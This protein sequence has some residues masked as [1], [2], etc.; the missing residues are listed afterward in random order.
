MD[1]KDQKEAEQQLLTVLVNQRTIV[2]KT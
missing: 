1:R 2:I